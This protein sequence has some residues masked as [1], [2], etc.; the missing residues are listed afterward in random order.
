M[1]ETV[2]VFA[3][4]SYENIIMNS[5]L[6]LL[7]QKTLFTLGSFITA[8]WTQIM[9]DNGGK[10]KRLLKINFHVLT[11]HYLSTIDRF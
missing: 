1:F 3:G 2:A 6:S 8:V 9:I 7:E 11:H 10:N 4:S 5:L